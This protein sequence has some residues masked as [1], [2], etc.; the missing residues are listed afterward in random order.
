MAK[1]QQL[2]TCPVYGLA[3]TPAVDCEVQIGRVTFIA[4][5]KI[6]RVRQR[7]GFKHPVS[8]YKERLRNSQHG[9]F[10][11]ADT[12][13]ILK[14]NRD[15]ADKNL[16]DEFREI[17]KAFWLFA[18]SFASY[19]HRKNAAMSLRPPHDSM[20]IRDIA[21][22]DRSTDGYNINYRFNAAKR[23][24]T[25]E[26]FWKQNR[27]LFHFLDLQKII[28]G[29]HRIDAKWKS[30][31]VRASTLFGQSFLAKH[32]AEAFTYNM[33]AI[34]T[35]LSEQGDSFPDS[36][37]DRIIAIFG[38]L[39]EENSE[40]WELMIKRLYRLRCGYVHDG[41]SGDINGMDLYNADRLLLNLLANL[42]ANTREIRSKADIIRLASELAAM[43]TLG[44]KPKRK[45]N[46][47]YFTSAI[48]QK[49]LDE[50]SNTSEW[51]W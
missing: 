30:S 3:L 5:K 39:H 22:F 38:W 44:M 37:V 14:T 45:A 33:I 13:A 12:Y 20:S 48:S 18:S 6:P 25:C 15:P 17:Q 21:V 19:S 50:I 35:L 27:K 43:S 8:H 26:G 2:L 24:N 7:L 49:E 42:C 10:T 4:A 1:S 28:E 29:K 11:N 16:S 34:E 40:P 46:F 51:E 47:F 31:I 9:I 41:K 23:P 36:L 32:L